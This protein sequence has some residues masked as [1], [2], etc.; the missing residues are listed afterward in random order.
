M[1]ARPRLKRALLLA[2]VWAAGGWVI[3]TVLLVI[4]WLA[5]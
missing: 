4:S 1:S 5:E 2:L 3:G